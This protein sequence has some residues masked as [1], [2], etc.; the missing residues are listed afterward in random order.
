MKFEIFTNVKELMKA[1]HVVFSWMVL[2]LL[3]AVA[4][5]GSIHSTKI[6]WSLGP[7]HPGPLTRT[8]PEEDFANL[9]SAGHLVRSGRLDWVYSSHLFEAWKQGQ[10]GAS[11]R[12]QDWIYPPTV[13]LLGVPLSYLPLVPA[14]I[15]WDIG[16]LIAAVLLL[17]WARLPWPILLVGLLGPAT[18][19]AL[20]LG[21]YGTITGALVI[22]GL[23]VAANKPV[24]AGIMLGFVTLKPQQGIIVPI[25]WFATRYWR[26][27]V[28]AGLTFGLLAA[29][30]IL[31]LGKH[32]WVLFF[33]QSNLM[34]RAILVMPPPQDNINSG[35]SVF[36]MCRTMGSNVAIAYDAQFIVALIAVILTFLAWRRQ[37]ADNLARIA[38]T[39][40]T[41]LMITPYGYTSDM[42]AFSIAVAIIVSNNRWRLRVIDVLL[43][44]WPAYCALITVHSG[45][46]FT[47]FVV[48]AAAALSW[49]Q[50]AGQTA[51]SGP[52]TQMPPCHPP[53]NIRSTLHQD[54]SGPH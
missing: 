45:I 15:L 31:W 9:W 19:R 10:F 48:A 49:R 26:A 35:V 37:N 20:I 3:G 54:R 53:Q 44:L 34:A 23:L 7:L 13:F 11:L 33:T 42:V 25:A 32:A 28:A 52:T 30:I 8:M 21:Q 12:T 5:Y 2:V 39:A 41:S 51:M 4:I 40:C 1:F 29:T 17:R 22:A 24:R 46:L 43:W 47:P 18:W 38:F 50:M 16:T 14:F 36:W 6:N 27:I